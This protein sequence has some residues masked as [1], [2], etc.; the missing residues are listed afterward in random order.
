M[1]DRNLGLRRCSYTVKSASDVEVVHSKESLSVSV[2]TLRLL[3][4][5]ESLSQ[6]LAPF[7]FS[8]LCACSGTKF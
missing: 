8:I 6:T 5:T 2:E 4:P 3:P 1:K 7:V